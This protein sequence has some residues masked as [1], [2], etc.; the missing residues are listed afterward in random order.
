MEPQLEKPPILPITA[1][2][3][4]QIVCK[5]QLVGCTNTQAFQLQLKDAP[6]PCLPA[7][8]VRRL[9]PPTDLHLVL[10]SPNLPHTII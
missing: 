1:K 6:T 9:R 7:T 10:A 2:L 3:Y 4:L 5:H 8:I